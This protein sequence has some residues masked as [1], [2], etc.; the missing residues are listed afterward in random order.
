[1]TIAGAIT[2][3]VGITIAAVMF[4]AVE[5]RAGA[6]NAWW[7]LLALP[8]YLVLGTAWMTFLHLAFDMAAFMNAEDLFPHAVV[9]AAVCAPFV[10][11]YLIIRKW[12]PESPLD[13]FPILPAMAYITPAIHFVDRWIPAW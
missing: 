8:F 2:I 11:A 13:L 3:I 9:L 4:Q 6:P 10:A 12:Y 5:A 7:K 1:M